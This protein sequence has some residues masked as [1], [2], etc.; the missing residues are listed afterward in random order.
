MP[1]TRVQRVS[2]HIPALR[3]A[4]L[5]IATLSVQVAPEYATYMIPSL[6]ADNRVW[7]IANAIA[8]VTD[9]EGSP[10]RGLSLSA[11]RV[12]RFVGLDTP[13]ASIEIK[14][15]TPAPGPTGDGSD[16]GFYLVQFP[17]NLPEQIPDF[18]E[19]IQS[20]VYSLEVRGRIKT[21]IHSGLAQ[22]LSIFAIA[23]FTNPAPSDNH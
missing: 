19:T 8:R 4:N 17:P 2:S 3:S 9:A 1:I 16:A 12:K 6:N 23:R 18:G 22:G 11:F 13:W 20:E 5:S 15:V 7:A 21:P 10:V 14:W